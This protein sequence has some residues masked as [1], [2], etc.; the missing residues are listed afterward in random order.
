MRRFDRRTSVL[1]HR[2]QRLTALL[3]VWGAASIA[4]DSQVISVSQMTTSKKQS[5]FAITV[6][7]CHEGSASSGSAI[8]ATRVTKARQRDQGRGGKVDAQRH[9]TRTLVT[10][11]YAT[12]P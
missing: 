11:E 9:E 2:G 8:P 6:A 12:A 7:D 10:F 3:I 5:A 4:S 1:P